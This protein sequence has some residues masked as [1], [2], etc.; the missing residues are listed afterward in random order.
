MM[1]TI[2]ALLGLA[3]LMVAGIAPGRADEPP[4]PKPLLCYSGPSMKASMEELARAY[5]TKAGVKVV[6]KTND[7]RSLIDRIKLA[8][9][10]D[11]FVS[12]DPFLAMLHRQEVPVRR[13]WTVASLVP[14]IAVAKGN[15]KQIKG[16]EDL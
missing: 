9:T 2:P 16:L 8:P 7:P 15:P 4:K 11:L 12:H 10:A 13:A 6:V 1:R 3:A 14:M 5:E